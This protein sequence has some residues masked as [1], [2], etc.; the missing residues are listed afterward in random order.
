MRFPKYR[1]TACHQSTPIFTNEVYTQTNYTFTHAGSF[2][3][4]FTM[5][6]LRYDSFDHFSLLFSLFLFSIK[7][8]DK[9]SFTLYIICSFTRI[10][11]LCLLS[12]LNNVITS[13][14]TS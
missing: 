8:I 7:F 1:I 5:P 10:S 2:K 3:V 13:F 14:I 9:R 12:I 6:T 11:S 4:Y